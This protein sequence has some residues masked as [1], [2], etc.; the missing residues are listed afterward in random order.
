MNCA[1]AT[2][3][4]S[5]YQVCKLRSET[6]HS[7]THSHGNVVVTASPA[8]VIITCHHVSPTPWLCDLAS[9]ITGWG[10][11]GG[12]LRVLASQLI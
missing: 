10:D 5:H 1:R 4:H 9:D 12:D 11:D 6:R 3:S 8:T 7:F 2:L